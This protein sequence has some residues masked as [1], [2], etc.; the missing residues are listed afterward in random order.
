MQRPTANSP[1]DATCPSPEFMLRVEDVLSGF[2]AE[3]SQSGSLQL[4]ADDLLA[5]RSNKDK[6]VLRK[7]EKVDLDDNH[8]DWVKDRFRRWGIPRFHYNWDGSQDDR[9]NQILFLFFLRTFDQVARLGLQL[10]NNSALA[11][12]LM[13]YKD[14]YSVI[15]AQTQKHF[16]HLTTERKRWLK[17]NTSISKRLIANQNAKHRQAVRQSVGQC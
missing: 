10:T 6:V 5:N 9:Y 2:D 8:L 12:A 7:M 14:D 16:E 4:P 13:K 15:M 17:D 11:M 3:R 1:Y